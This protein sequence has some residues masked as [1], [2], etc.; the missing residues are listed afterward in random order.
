MGPTTYHDLA[1]KPHLCD[2]MLYFMDTLTGSLLSSLFAWAIS[3]CTPSSVAKDDHT[4]VIEK[5][6]TYS[7]TYRSSDSSVPCIRI[8]T[9][10]PVVLE[11]C[12]LAGAGD[13]IRANTNGADLIVRGCSG[14]GL[15]PSVDDQTRGRFLDIAQPKRLT[16]E[17]N[18]LEQTTGIVVY[19]WSG[20]GSPQQTLTV[21]YNLAHNING[22]FRNGNGS[23]RSSFLLLNTV[24]HL[25]G[26]EVS[27]NEVQNLPD[28]SA[29]EDNIN[30]YNSSGTAESPA[31]VHDNYVQG[32]YPYP[33]TAEHFTGTGMT[34][35]G[36]GTTAATTTAHVEAYNNQFVGTCN[37]AMNIAAG[38]DIY[39]HDNRM[40]AS[41]LLPDG[42]KLRATYAATAVFNYYKQPSSVFFNNR[43]ANNTIGYVRWGAAS[44]YPNRQDLSPDCA[45]CI[46]T[47]HL[48]NPVTIK[49]EQNEQKLWQQKLKKLHLYV[50]VGSK[51]AG[52]PTKAK[53]ALKERSRS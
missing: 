24:Q 52:G 47:K 42:T 50:G 34:T 35:D 7:G 11:N 10:E 29:V 39:Y 31:R 41:G 18:Y 13:L 51:P 15:P 17:H 1:G 16:L 14:Y 45:T 46:G 9:T 3:A 53:P 4:I 33:A 22:R 49:V 20:N 2:P 43:T 36:D 48:P 37:A 32:A 5:G 44:P 30:F 21:R 12:I 38:H 26:I 27:F 28:Q 23:T 40:V 6:G 8:A 19:R 25:A